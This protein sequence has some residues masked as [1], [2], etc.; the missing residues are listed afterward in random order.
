MW[1]N[2]KTLT[3]LRIKEAPFTKE[4][5]IKAVLALAKGKAPGL[6]GFM[7]KTFKPY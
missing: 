1:A 2:H 6:D 5:L 4:E 7:A 3:A